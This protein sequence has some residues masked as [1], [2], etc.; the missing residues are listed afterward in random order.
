VGGAFVATLVT[1][2]ALGLSLGE[3][4][5]RLGVPV[6]PAG[7]DVLDIAKANSQVA[8][9]KRRL[10]NRADELLQLSPVRS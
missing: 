3:Y 9:A 1:G 8:V 7:L 4:L 2:I 5:L 10:E 6:L